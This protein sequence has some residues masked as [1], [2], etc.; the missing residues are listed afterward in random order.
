MRFKI[1][2]DY[3]TEEVPR[4]FYVGKGTERRLKILKR[5][6]LHTE[7]STKYG[8][9]R[10]VVFET[11][12]EQEAFKKECDLIVEHNTFIY[13]GGWGANFTLGGEGTTGHPKLHL[14]GE[15]HPMFGRKH[16]EESKRKNS[17]SN[18]IS[19]S[20]ERNGMY[21]RRHSEETRKKIGDNQRGWHHTEKTKVKLAEAAKRL[22][23]GRKHTEQAR[24]ICQKQEKEKS[25]GTRERKLEKEKYQESFQNRHARTSLKR[26]RVVFHGIRVARLSMIM[27]LALKRNS[28]FVIGGSPTRKVYFQM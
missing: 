20:D 24:K 1:Y 13:D 9:D 26:V 22:H 3:T 23:T 10:R 21:G 15:T 12:D 5:N 14:H 16:S 6:K 11:D 17:E 19:C 27:K 4:P 25:R 2:V 18:K 28:F 7:I 8:F